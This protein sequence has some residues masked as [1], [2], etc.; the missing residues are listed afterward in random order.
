MKKMIQKLIGWYVDPI[1][2]RC[3]LLER[4][5]N[6]IKTAFSQTQRH[7]TGHQEQLN[8]H[9]E[10]LNGHQ[11]QLNGHQEQLNGHQEQLNG[12][13]EQLNGYQEQLNSQ[14]EQLDGH[15]EQLNGYQEQIDSHQEQLNGHQEQLNGHQE[16]LTRHQMLIDECILQVKRTWK[17]V[18]ATQNGTGT[19]PVRYAMMPYHS[20][21]VEGIVYLYHKEDEEIPDCMDRTGMNYSKYDIDNFLS[22]ADK[23]FYNGNPPSTGLFLDIGGNIG[24]T[25]I[26]CKQKKKPQL[27]YIAFEPV[28]RN[29]KLF[30]ANCIMNGCNGIKVEKIALS[31][32]KRHN[33]AMEVSNINSGNSKLVLSDE[34]HSEQLE[35]GINTIKLDEYLEEHKICPEEIRYIWLDVE[36]HETEVLEGAKKLLT[37]ADIPMCM[38]Y[39]QDIYQENGNYENMLTLLQ[40]YFKYF[41]VC[42]QYAE[43]KKQ[44]R[45]VSE[46]NLLWEEI[47]YKACDL[48]LW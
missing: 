17:A 45:P 43:G 23:Q 20:I 14:R 18:S 35:Y 41:V 15:Q 24:T 7:I 21:E 5:M 4:Q 40:R 46:L 2:S 26:Y 28:E 22:L 42:S 11:E 48:I 6:D 27:C 31:N 36:G 25:T 39:N 3:E 34:N 10:Q 29:A 13:Q 19:T 32:C 30:E 37:N 38:E 9:Q 44:V 8:G 12:H 16:Q 47:G 33:V 1:K